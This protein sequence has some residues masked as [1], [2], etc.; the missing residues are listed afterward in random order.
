MGVPV[1]RLLADGRRLRRRCQSAAGVRPCL[2]AATHEV[3]VRV[4]CGTRGTRRPLDRG[5]DTD[6]HGRIRPE[7]SYRVRP[8]S[9]ESCSRA[10]MAGQ[11]LRTAF[12]IL[13]DVKLPT[14]TTSPR[15][16]GR[17]D[18]ERVVEVALRLLDEV[19][20]DGLTLRRLA[21]EL[22]VRAPALYW[23]FANK[24]ELLDHMAHAVHLERAA[25]GVRVP[26]GE[27]WEDWMAEVARGYRKVLLS[28]R[29]GARLVA[30]TR[31]L[32]DGLPLVNGSIAALRQATG[33]SA[34]R[35]MRCLVA[36]FTYVTG[37]VLDEQAEQHRNADERHDAI[38]DQA[39]LRRLRADDRAPHLVAALEEIG[40]PNGEGTFEF[41]LR[42][43]VDGMRTALLR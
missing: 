12:R 6:S 1:P 7:L 43:I 36:V 10:G 33:C 26:T 35:A 9:E 19:G 3:T 5:T 4:V 21:A 25:G 14:V 42:M 22:D 24:R 15:R 32:E 31:P 18:R 30:G 39:F 27:D 11:Q 34:G 29:D 28:H 23:H 13:N 17:L 2:I 20:L 8:V 40:D 16:A 38:D 41:G 37:F